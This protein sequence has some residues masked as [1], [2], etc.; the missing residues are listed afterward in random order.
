MK[1]AE[2]LSDVQMNGIKVDVSYCKKAFMDLQ[3]EVK[4]LK[5]ELMSYDEIRRWKHKYGKG[6]SFQSN[7]QLA[8]ILYNELEYEPIKFTDTGEPSTEQEALELTGA[9]FVPTLVKYNQT[10]R[11]KDTYIKGILREVVDGRIHPFFNLNLVN[12]YRSSSDAINF[13]NLPI[14]NPTMGSVVRKAIVAG[15]NYHLVEVDYSGIEVMGS[16]WHHQDP[17]MLA[18]IADPSSDM[19]GDTAMEIYKMDSLDKGTCEKDI[20]KVSKNSFV[21]PEFYGDYWRSCAAQLWNDIYKYNLKL[22]DGTPLKTHLKKHG[23]KNYKQFEIHIKNMEDHFWNNRFPVYNQ[24]RKDRVDSYNKL[25]Y[26]DSLFG[27]RFQGV[28]QKNKIFNYPIQ[29]LQGHVKVL[30][31][32]GHI[33]IKD[34]VHK[35][36][37]IWTGF[38]WADAIGMEKGV[39]KKAQIELSSGL[40]VDCDIEHYLKN[41]NHEWVH[42]NDMY[43]GMKVAL[44]ITGSSIKPSTKITWDFVL[45]FIIGDGSL[46]VQK[47]RKYVAIVVGETKKRDLYRIKNFLSSCGYKGYKNLRITTIKTDGYA[48]RYKLQ[49]EDKKF[50]KDLESFDLVFGTTAHN[51]KLPSYIWTASKQQ[52]I[53]FMEGL[54]RSDGSRV[55][56]QEKNLHM[57]NKG[58]LQDI[59]NLISP[60]GFDTSL[61]TTKQGW[62]L[63]VC[64]R[65]TNSKPARKVPKKVIDKVV[66]PSSIK[67]NLTD[68]STIT[69]RRAMSKETDISQYVAERIIHRYAPSGSE[70]YRYDTIENITI[71]DEK[72]KMYTMAVKDD[73]HQFV[74]DG[75]IHH[76]CDSFH[77]LLWSLTRMNNILKKGKWKSK[78]I[79]QIHDSIVAEVHTKELNDY[80]ALADNV[81][82]HEIRKANKFI[83][84]HLEIEADVTP[85]GGS[86]N[87]KKAYE[88]KA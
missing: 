24:W 49:I 7:K 73:L 75:V 68:L 37:K 25:G 47:N 43:K 30:T 4:D 60:L 19:H 84:T 44:P 28:L 16:S 77:C 52:Q 12:T 69:D 51:K 40:V 20:R 72:D 6:F 54:W 27:F 21:F 36:C 11:V 83:I 63:R 17:N 65:K 64:E 18:Y 9:A 86:W 59:Q 74:A 2:A 57:C 61:K 78:I 79:G 62:L 8:D 82:C 3:K 35:A 15:K 85:K 46:T 48:D 88:I 34:L 23:I 70:I 50:T 81:M 1:G 53:D 31:D 41:E 14:R 29:C 13:Q 26:G 42:F 58:L 76:N 67:T 38:K 45:G 10:T 87:D 55:K 32:K 33:P 80:L 39:E 22:K 5:E 66:K 56:W 71:Y